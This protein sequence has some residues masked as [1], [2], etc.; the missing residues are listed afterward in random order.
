MGKLRC[1]S[2]QSRCASGWTCSARRGGLIGRLAIGVVVLGMVLGAGRSLCAAAGFSLKPD[3][4]Y[5]TTSK[6]ARQSALRSIPFEQL[7][8]SARAKVGS[9]LSNLSV[10]RRMPVRVI[11]C[12]PDMY[13]FLVR[14]PDVVVNIWDVLNI[15]KLQL[16]QLGDDPY[17]LAEDE[18]TLGKVE[19]LYSSHDTHVIY[20]EGTYEGPLFARP[21]SGRCL[22]V[23]R[24]GYVREPDGRYYITTRLDTFLAVDHQCVELLT[25]AFHPL[26]GRTADENFVQT[27]TF[28]GCLSRTAEVNSRG[29]QRLAT[30]LEYVRPELRLQLAELAEKMASDSPRLA[31]RQRTHHGEIRD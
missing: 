5:A 28:L 21:V 22:A 19:F 18:G 9:V 30:K 24:T 8:Q 1:G 3:P 14:N 25:K 29:V 15:T 26:I 4:R 13:L 11:D 31:Q 27:V 20:G 16:R 7:D 12:D 6:S 10:F 2:V 23:L 17:R